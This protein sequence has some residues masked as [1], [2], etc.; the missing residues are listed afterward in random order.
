MYIYTNTQCYLLTLMFLLTMDW[1]GS[2]M[3]NFYTLRSLLRLSLTINTILSVL[4]ISLLHVHMKAIAHANNLPLTLAFQVIFIRAS[5]NFFVGT[6][7]GMPGCS[8]TTN[9]ASQN[10]FA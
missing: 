10:T 3:L 7:P 6:G 8:Y 9:S 5:V 2:V 4:P 1:V